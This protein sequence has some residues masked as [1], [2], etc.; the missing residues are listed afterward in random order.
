MIIQ[1]VARYF[2]LACNKKIQTTTFSPALKSALRYLFTSCLVIGAQSIQAQHWLTL[3]TQDFGTGTAN[4]ISATPLT[5]LSPGTTQYTAITAWGISPD[6]GYYAIS[7]NSQNGVTARDAWIN[8]N[9]HTTGT[10]TGTGTGRMM[11]I[12]ANPDMQ[13]VQKGTIIDLPVSRKAVPG[14]TYSFG[15]YAANLAHK[16]YGLKKGYLGVGIFT[17]VG[18]TGTNLSLNSYVL[19]ETTSFSTTILPWASYPSSFTLPTS[20]TV[21]TIYVDIYNSDS[22][23]NAYGNDFV[24][25]DISLKQYVVNLSGTVYTDPN[26][27]GTGMSAYAPGTETGLLPLYVVLVDNNN[28]VVSVASVSPSNGTYSFSDVPYVASGDIGMKLI[29]TSDN[30]A[31]GTTKFAPASASFPKYLFPT[32]SDK[33]N[34]SSISQNVTL[35]NVIDIN[36][37]SV[38]ITTV[39]FG[40]FIADFGDM[41]D[42]YGTTIANNGA[43]SAVN[44]NYLRIGATVDGENDGTPGSDATGDGADEDGISTIPSL[45]QNATDYSLSVSVY[46]NTG[47]PKTLQGWIDFNRN[48]TF[49]T[50]EYATVTVPTSAS[51]QLVTL[52]WSGLSGGV[53]GTSYFRLRLNDD[54]TKSAIDFKGIKGSGEVE[55][56][57]L[58][59]I[60]TLPIAANQ[61][62]CGSTTVASLVSTVPPGAFV[63]WY[64]TSTSGTAINLTDVLSTTRTYYA[65]SQATTGGCVSTS[66]TPVLV[67]INTILEPSATNHAFCGSARVSDLVATPGANGDV[68]DWYAASSGGSALTSTTAL[69]NATDYYAQTRN[70]ITSCVSSIR[71]KITVTVNTIPT[72]PTILAGSATTFCTGSSVELSSSATTGNQWHKDGTAISGA[73]SQTYSATTSGVYTVV[74]TTSGCDS[75]ASYATTVTVNTIPTKPTISAGSATTFC[76]GSSVELSSSATTGNQWYKDGIAISGATAQTYSATTSGAYTVVVTRTGCESP[77]SD[78][79]TVTV[80]NCISLTN[81]AVTGING[82]TGNSNVINAL[83]NDKLNGVAVA[84]ADVNLT[85]IST[86]NPKVTLNVADGSVSVAGGTAAGTYVINYSICENLNPTNCSTSSISVTVDPAAIQATTD[87]VT[88]INGKTGNSNVINALTNDKLNGVAVAIADVNLSVVTSATS[89]GSG[90][91]PILNPA[92]GIVSVAAGT[93]A[94]VY[95]IIYSICEKLN[96]TNCNLA[97]VTVTVFFTN[98]PP[99]IYDPTNTTFDPLTGKY[100]VIITK[101]CSIYNN[102]KAIDGNN[103]D[104]IY[105]KETDPTHGTVIVNS[106]GTY[107]YTPIANYSGTDSFTISVNDGKGGFTSVTV[108]VIVIPLPSITKKASK[109]VLDSDGKTFRW[110]YTITVI[111]DTE[112]RIDS[113]Q[114][115]DDLDKVFLSK[116]CTY[117]VT[118]KSATRT[119]WIN[120]LYNGSNIIETLLSNRSYLNSQSKDSIIFEVKVNTNNYIGNVFNQAILNAYI[121]LTKYQ[122]SNI[123]SDDLGYG[124]TKDTTVTPLLPIELFIPDG[125]S[126]NNDGW[127]QTFV[128]VHSNT[129]K[130]EFEVFNCWGNS[131]YKNSDYQND[132]D[133]KGTGNFLGQE[134]PTGTYYCKYNAINTKNGETVAKGVKNITLRR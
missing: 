119:L 95:T 43:E 36:S 92:T 69:T 112:Q 97:T 102:V 29:L 2:L 101:N 109:P 25:D 21:S 44:A 65:E 33:S 49:D 104:L 72:K 52:V 94:G 37:S 31:V 123:L 40:I 17:G 93:P 63:N 79:T 14:S 87:A 16:G 134:L 32:G 77:A 128:I 28:T 67:T 124:G 85:Q 60:P 118:S 61:T 131:V 127:N 133:G 78:A 24:I 82:K 121:P 47:S 23:P 80:N 70:S 100:K 42:T 105:T 84:I 5:I 34:V 116:G 55:D 4:S 90:S 22:D 12:N 114:V 106:D 11:I 108:D 71:K 103:D 59:I 57:T 15:I 115:V 120:G 51:Q 68:V 26:W 38:D 45:V 88:G 117:E 18:G 113:I 53:A 86:D 130:I 75:P 76:T 62:F 7:T 73:T 1:T 48:G 89:I 129:I 132:W 99:V 58:C 111:N 35:K 13:G 98:D 64:I 126:P 54:A 8:A 110:T 107:T 10:G 3:Y 27:N 19:P 81:D 122:L 20:T 9:D 41:P 46:N 39:D 30:P 91:V 6:D 50:G 125:F 56:Y 66:R 74:V 83:T 96:P